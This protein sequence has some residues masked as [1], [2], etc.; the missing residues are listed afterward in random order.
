M[1]ET[2][3]DLPRIVLFLFFGVQFVPLFIKDEVLSVCQIHTQYRILEHGKR[4]DLAIRIIPVLSDKI[5]GHPTAPSDSS[6]LNSGLTQ[7]TAPL[8][9][10]ARHPLEAEATYGSVVPG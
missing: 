8:T 4:A 3:P 10:T 9:F 7:P 5:I 1:G 2:L 6:W